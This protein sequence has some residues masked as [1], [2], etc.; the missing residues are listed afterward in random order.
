MEFRTRLQKNYTIQLGVS[1]YGK[2]VKE[3]FEPYGIRSRCFKIRMEENEIILTPIQ[4]PEEWIEKDYRE[5]RRHNIVVLR[6]AFCLRKWMRMMGW[7]EGEYIE[8][9]VNEGKMKIRKAMVR[10]GD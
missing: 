3:L 9:V 7:K 5:L 10:I 1:R 4:I 6:E 8:V 2:I